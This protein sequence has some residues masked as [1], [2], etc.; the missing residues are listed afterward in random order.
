MRCVPL[1]AMCRIGG[2]GAG[3]GRSVAEGGGGAALGPERAWAKAGL[4]T[5]V[6]A[7]SRTTEA[8]RVT[9]AN[10]AFTLIHSS[11][12]ARK[13]PRALTS[14]KIRKDSGD[15]PDRSRERKAPNPESTPAQTEIQPPE[16]AHRAGASERPRIH[17]TE[18]APR[19]A[20]E[21]EKGLSARCLQ[22][23]QLSVR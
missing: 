2:A 22:I 12:E 11:L 3:G 16:P 4:A 7:S 8:V 1:T 5:R 13:D 9:W 20:P 10:R 19:R 14:R 17:S 21:S 18:D 23:V 15:E 6:Q